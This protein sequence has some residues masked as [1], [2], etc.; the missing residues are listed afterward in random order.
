LCWK[1]DGTFAYEFRKGEPESTTVVGYCDMAEPYCDLCWEQSI[2]WQDAMFEYMSQG[3]TVW[4]AF[5]Q[6][7]ADYPACGDSGCVRFAGDHDFAVV[8]VV[9]RD[10]WP[11]GVTLTQPDGGETLESG[12]L[13]EITWEATDNGLVDSVAILLSLDGG[14]TYPDTIAAGEPNDSSYVWDVPD[15]DSKTARIKVVATDCALNEGE[16]VS[17]SD[18]VLWGTI[19]GSDEP[20][21]TGIPPGIVLRI[22]DGNPVYGGSRITFGL[23]FPGHVRLAVYDV[24]GRCLADLMEGSLEEG[25]HSIRWSAKTANGSPLSPGLYFLRLDTQ[26]GGKTTKAVVAR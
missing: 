9:Q 20:A 13:Y 8:P 10:P 11:P 12:I 2:L 25:Y 16:D 18:F 22:S 24:A 26:R 19:S 4:D 7:R 3:W 21:E 5:S 17:D 15:L 23:P 1:F 6:A 14:L